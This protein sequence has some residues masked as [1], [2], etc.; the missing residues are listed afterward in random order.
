[1]MGVQLANVAII[2]W[3]PVIS[4]R[5]FRVLMRMSLTA[6]DKPSNGQ[7]A[8]HYFGG[9]DLLSMT[10]RGG[11]DPTHRTTRRALSELVSVGAIESA[12][13]GK[14]GARAVYRLTLDADPKPM[15]S[16]QGCPTDWTDLSRNS[17]GSGQ[18]SP[19]S[20][21]LVSP[22]GTTGATQDDERQ[23]DE[24]VAS[25]AVVQTAR[26]ESAA[27]D[28]LPAEDGCCPDCGTYLDPDG[29]CFNRH[30]PLTVVA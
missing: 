29:T 7:P 30:C 4:D 16:G 21:H 9:L 18:V 25:P 3:A 8:A 20:G 27:N 2:R 10:L 6:L 26:D 15:V 28:D 14:R 22:L 17:D 19:G 1:M 12:Q 13:K 23:E 11:G 5:A 24:V